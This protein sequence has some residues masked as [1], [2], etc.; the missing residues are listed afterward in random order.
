MVDIICFFAEP[1]GT[2]LGKKKYVVSSWNLKNRYVRSYAGSACAFI[3][4]LLFLIIFKDQF[5]F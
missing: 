2:Y 1:V 4:A 5:V 3:A